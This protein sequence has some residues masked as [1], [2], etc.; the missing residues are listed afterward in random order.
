MPA[1]QALKGT[2]AAADF[3]VMQFDDTTLLATADFINTVKKSAGKS[4]S[5]QYERHVQWLLSR[6]SK[7]SQSVEQLLIMSI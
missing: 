1:F 7:N 4:P 2:S 3:E 6:C 5:D